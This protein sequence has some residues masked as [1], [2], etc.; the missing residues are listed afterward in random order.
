M[1]A[2][3]RTRWTTTKVVDVAGAAYTVRTYL[4]QADVRRFLTKVQEQTAISAACDVGAGYGRLSVV[5]SEFSNRVVA[6]EREE[7]FVREAQLLLPSVN[8]VQIDSLS[9]LPS[10]SSQFQFAMTFTVLQHLTHPELIGAVNEIKRIVTPGG[11]VLLCE[12]TDPA[13]QYAEHDSL[14][15][16]VTIGRHVDVYK[17]C[18]APFRLVETAPRRVEPGYH[19]GG[20]YMLFKALS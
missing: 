7:H 12:E 6:Y 4:E 13:I 14:E 9:E 15:G 20:T 5:L 18:M 3:Q 17:Q 2:T 10:A 8:F 16:G 11:Y 1:S 19:H